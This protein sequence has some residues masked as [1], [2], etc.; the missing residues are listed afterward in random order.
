MLAFA[1]AIFAQT[2]ARERAEDTSLPEIDNLSGLKPDESDLLPSN[3]TDASSGTLENGNTGV[4]T[5]NGHDAS[6]EGQI[7]T[8]KSHAIDNVEV[9]PNPAQDFV[10]VSIDG[11]EGT[12]QV[13]NLLGQE[14][15]TITISGTITTLDVSDLK[16]G[17]YFLSITS[18]GEN[19]VKRIK[20]L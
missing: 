20:V 11:T 16:E 5:E 7:K 2:N 10:Y 8:D 18:N 17:I 13:L 15:H 14:V 1:V 4:A 3:T 6:H 12:I 9:Y 19:I